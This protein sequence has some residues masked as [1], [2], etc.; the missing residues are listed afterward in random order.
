MLQ[1]F[2]SKENLQTFNLIKKFNINQVVKTLNFIKHEGHLRKKI[3]HENKSWIENLD[4][5]RSFS[6]DK[7]IEILSLGPSEEDLKKR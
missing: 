5:S 4:K 2:Y 3:R 7:F 6:E 1:I